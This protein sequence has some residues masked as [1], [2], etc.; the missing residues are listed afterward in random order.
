[1]FDFADPD[2]LDLRY[3]GKGRCRT[4]TGADLYYESVGS[5]PPLVFLNNFFIVAPAWRNFTSRLAQDHT[6][7]T[8]DLRNQGVSTPGPGEAHFD[9]HVEDLRDLLDH[10]ALDAVHLVGTSASTLICRDFAIRHPERVRSLVLTG[11]AFSPTARC[12]CG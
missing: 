7:V 11:P 8:Y 12:A 10:L 4:T 2:S 9:Q 3:R 5:G 1:M 6:V